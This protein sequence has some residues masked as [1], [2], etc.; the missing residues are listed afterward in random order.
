VWVYMLHDKKDGSDLKLRT[1]LV[2]DT[3]SKPIDF[4]F[5]RSRGT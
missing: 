5:N 2:V 4:A 1:M 3:V